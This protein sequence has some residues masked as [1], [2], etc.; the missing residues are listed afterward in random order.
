M[1]DRNKQCIC[2][3]RTV[4]NKWCCHLSWVPSGTISVPPPRR[5][6]PLG[7]WLE[8]LRQ[9]L[10]G[11]ALPSCLLALAALPLCGTSK[12]NG[13]GAGC[14]LLSW[15]PRTPVPPDR[16]HAFSQPPF[17]STNPQGDTEHS[18]QGHA[19]LPLAPRSFARCS[20]SQKGE[21]LF[22]LGL[23]LASR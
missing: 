10:R 11:A 8:P 7:L 15:G 12:R 20:I 19:L 14:P 3:V 16:M 1:N 13:T 21:G 22:N 23:G 18:L 6:W 5:T 4:M 2:P 9:L 17:L